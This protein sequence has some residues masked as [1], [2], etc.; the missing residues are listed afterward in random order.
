MFMGNSYTGWNQLPTILKE[1]ALEAGDSIFVDGNVI[2]GYT[3]GIP[4]Q[5]HL[6]NTTSIGM[7]ER[8]YWDYVIMQEQS[9]MPTIPYY[10]DGYTFPAA[11][12]LNKIIQESNACVKTMF[13]MTWGRKYG[14]EQC[15]NTHCSPV[16]VDYFHMQDS[17][18]SAYMYMTLSNEAMCA[19][20]GIS[21]SNSIANGDPIELFAAD[22]SHPSLAGSYL[23]ACTFYAA[24]FQKS[25]LG[26]NYNAGLSPADAA[27]LQ[28]IAETTV[29]TNPKQWNIF[30]LDTLIASFSFELDGGLASFVNSSVNTH[31]YNWNFGDPLSGNQN[32][33]SMVNPT[34]FY[35]NPGTYYVSLQ[36]GDSCRYDI[37]Y[38]SLVILDVGLREQ[39]EPIVQCFPNPVKDLLII[40]SLDGLFHSW[41][42]ARMDGCVCLAGELTIENKKAQITGLSVLTPGIYLL[43]LTGETKRVNKKII[44]SPQ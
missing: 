11:D 34:H 19:P 31:V 24:I 40:K 43:S 2:G 16:F 21:W 33:S 12:S 20:V 41:Q 4:G 42:I 6:H 14:G 37:A 10:R 7:I 26:I 44:I 27:Y 36:A 35:E 18:E 1:L 5:G 17:L 23:A 25:P 9:Q 22:Q 29:L 13:F 39:D 8:G 3:L 28:E 32:T 30:P 38:D 15:V